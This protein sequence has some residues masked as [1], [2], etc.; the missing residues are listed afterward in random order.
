[1]QVSSRSV[2]LFIMA[3]GLL[4]GCV[5][6]VKPSPQADALAE[7]RI[8]N[9][10]G[11]ADSSLDVQAVRAVI[12]QHAPEIRSCYEQRLTANPG[13]QGKVVIRWVIEADGS[14]TRAA[15]VDE[16]TTLGDPELH[17]CMTSRMATWRFQKRAVPD[18]GVGRPDP[19]VRRADHDARRGPAGAPRPR[20]P[21]RGP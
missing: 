14:V 10:E 6:A 13:I 3:A 18:H 2:R 17:A 19:E 1:M 21:A 8:Q 12:R 11:G 15:V 5:H 16:S 7:P 4:A 9:A 20:G